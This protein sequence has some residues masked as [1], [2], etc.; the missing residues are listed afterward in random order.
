[1][2]LKL[3]AG[4]G[5]TGLAFDQLD[6][7]RER[8]LAVGQRATDDGGRVSLLEQFM[9]HFDTR[10][11]HSIEVHAPAQAVF[12]AVETVTVKEVRFLRELEFIRALPRLAATGRLDVPTVD[13]PLVLTSRAAPYCW[14]R[15]HPKKS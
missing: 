3:P 2:R 12:T 9:P 11:Q 1:M 4:L 7:D 8:G 14:A 10:S 5:C 6:L 13:A 15:G